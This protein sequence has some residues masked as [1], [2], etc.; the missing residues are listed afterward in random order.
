M[1]SCV[2][3]PRFLARPVSRLETQDEVCLVDLLWVYETV[4][5]AVGEEIR[6]IDQLSKKMQTRGVLNVPMHPIT[7]SLL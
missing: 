5:A 6:S 7:S 1:Y 3:H 2:T 4:L